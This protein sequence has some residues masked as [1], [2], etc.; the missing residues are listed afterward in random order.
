[1]FDIIVIIIVFYL[2]LLFVAT[3]INA[4]KVNDFEFI[5]FKRYQHILKFVQNGTC[6]C[7]NKCIVIF[8]VLCLSNIAAMD[9]VLRSVSGCSL[10]SRRDLYNVSLS[11]TRCSLS[12]GLSY[13]VLYRESGPAS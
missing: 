4:Q 13:I 3:G 2:L 9:T 1:M 8:I 11:G 12:P 7:L 6:F 10:F 5:T